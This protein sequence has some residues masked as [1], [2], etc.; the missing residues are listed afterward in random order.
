MGQQNEID[1][2]E[3]M[4]KLRHSRPGWREVARGGLHLLLAGLTGSREYVILPMITTLTMQ[5]FHYTGTDEETEL[6]LLDR[7]KGWLNITDNN[8]ENET[9]SGDTEHLFSFCL[10]S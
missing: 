10:N 8:S 5:L 9:V 6:M 1:A 2:D 3:I 4:S 7:L